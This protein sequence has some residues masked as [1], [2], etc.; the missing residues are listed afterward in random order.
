ML[1]SKRRQDNTLKGPK[2]RKT[3]SVLEYIE[4]NKVKKEHYLMRQ[5]NRIYKYLINISQV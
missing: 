2:T 3:A 5:D 1:F 4:I